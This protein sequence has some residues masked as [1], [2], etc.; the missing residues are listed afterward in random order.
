MAE[1]Q[2]PTQ[3]PS[4]RL[5]LVPEGRMVAGV[6][7]GL[8]RHTGIDPVVYRVGFALLT[9]AHGQGILLYIAAAVLMPSRPETYSL[10]EQLLRRWFD[11]AGALSILGALL[12][13]GVLGSLVGAGVSPDALGAVTVLG[14]VLLVAHARGANFVGLARALPERLQGHPLQDLS[15]I[16]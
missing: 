9:L 14:L 5:S 3:A 7:T 13:V 15:L 16:H 8:G 4:P 6:C 12:S 1:Q 11:A 10:V 2:V